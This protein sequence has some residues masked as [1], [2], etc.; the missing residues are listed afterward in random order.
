[1]ECRSMKC[2]DLNKLN[3]HIIH[4][5]SQ[6]SLYHRIN[7]KKQNYSLKLFLGV[8]G[9]GN[10]CQTTPCNFTGNGKYRKLIAVFHMSF[11]LCLW[12]A[13]TKENFKML[14]HVEH[15]KKQE[16]WHFCKHALDVSAQ[17][18]QM[19][20]QQL[21]SYSNDVTVHITGIIIYWSFFFESLRPNRPKSFTACHAVKCWILYGNFKIKSKI[22]FLRKIE[23]LFFLIMRGNLS[24]FY[25]TIF[26]TCL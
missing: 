5:L 15:Y 20:N 21:Y 1:M 2:K 25:L 12:S 7:K 16:S 26:S 6:V 4:K 23:L 9:L 11:I 13:P 10:F 17:K 14:K 3:Y 8:N 19:E 22:L 24:S 18:L